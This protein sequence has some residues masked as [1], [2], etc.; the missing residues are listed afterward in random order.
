MKGEQMRKMALCLAFVAACA[1]SALVASDQAQSATPTVAVPGHDT[2][3]AHRGES[4]DAPENT[5]PAYQTAVERDFGFECDVYLSQ[6]GRV[7]TFHDS[8]L[9][10]T[11][12]GANT[13]ACKDVTWAEL[14]KVD[15][16]NWGK[17]KDSRFK[18]TRPALLEEVLELARDG[19]WIYVEVKTGPEIVPYV[20]EILAKQTKATPNNTLFISFHRD[21]CKALKEAI[22]QY[23]VYFLTYSRTKWDDNAPPVTVA[24]I[25]AALRETGADGVDC[26]FNPSIVTADYVKAVRTAGFE[27]HVWTVDNLAD[28][29]E[30]FHR[31][32]QTVTTNCAKKQVD[33]WNTAKELMRM[34]A[35]E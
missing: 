2:R 29:I 17:W 5:L 12:D 27:F 31:G 8:T 11:T 7:F 1:L 16:G 32:A 18:G 21:A 24:D 13:K 25:I 30:A 10:R 9:K 20:K 34:N 22:P 19:R 15:V 14:E 28:T 35:R 33:A 4:V 26:H 6:D 23:K 3:I